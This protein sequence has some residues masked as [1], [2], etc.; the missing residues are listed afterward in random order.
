MNKT[1]KRQLGAILGI[2]MVG[3]LV[4]SSAFASVP[5][6]DGTINGCY[7]ATGVMK[8][9]LVIIDSTDTCPSG[10]TALNWNQTGPAGL[11]GYEIVTNTGLTGWTHTINCPAG[12]KVMSGG[13]KWNGLGTISID[14]MKMVASYPESDGIGWTVV[15]NMGVASTVD[16]YAI[17]VNA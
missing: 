3:T 17:C 5:A 13:V 2:T 7:R 11:S 12:K 6:G 10:Y 4:G 9:D 1:R 16:A 15:Y 8:G 14:Q